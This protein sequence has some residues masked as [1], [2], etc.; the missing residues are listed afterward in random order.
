VV[1]G[2]QQHLLFIGKNHRLD[3]VNHLSNVG[4]LHPIGMSMKDVQRDGRYFSV[5]QAI[6]L[7][8]KSKVRACFRVVPRTPFVD[9]QCDP[10]AGVISV[11]DR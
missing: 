10:F 1:G 4:H 9:K 2:S 8:Q 5:E 7:I 11:D 6:L 3:H